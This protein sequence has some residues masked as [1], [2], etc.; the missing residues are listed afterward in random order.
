[1]ELAAVL[2]VVAEEGGVAAVTSTSQVAAV[3]QQVPDFF[4]HVQQVL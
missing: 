2:A 1:M 3:E 4:Q